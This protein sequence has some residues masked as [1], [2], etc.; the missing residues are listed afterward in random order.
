MLGD[1]D[2]D[3]KTLEAETW[4]EWRRDLCLGF[5]LFEKYLEGKKNCLADKLSRGQKL[6]RFT[7]WALKPSI[8]QHIFQIMG[9]PNID[10]FATRANSQLPVFCSPYPDPL[11]WTCDALSVN[12]EGIFAYAFPPPIL[13]PKVLM[14]V[15]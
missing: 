2:K 1:L 7:E 13:I 3:F 9:T 10:L 11:A 6:V 14:K 5:P 8:V 15:R 12:W 4:H